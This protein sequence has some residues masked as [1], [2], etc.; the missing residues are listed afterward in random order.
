MGW[1]DLRKGRQTETRAEVTAQGDG[2]RDE[3]PQ[4]FH[5]QPYRIVTGEPPYSGDSIPGEHRFE[6]S[7]FFRETQVNRASGA[8]AGSSDNE[9]C[10]ALIGIVLLITSHGRWRKLHAA[11]CS[12]NTDSRR[13]ESCGEWSPPR[14]SGARLNWDRETT[15]TLQFL[16]K[17]FRTAGDCGNFL[18]AF[19]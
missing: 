18:S 10:L 7:Q 5:S 3:V 11:S 4:P 19:S 17:A 8:V 9:F 13:S 1:N 2:L 16:A 12:I 15:G 14:L 6:S